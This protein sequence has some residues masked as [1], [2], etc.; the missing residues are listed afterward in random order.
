MFCLRVRLLIPFTL[1]VAGIRCAEPKAACFSGCRMISGQGTDVPVPCV[2]W[3]CPCEHAASRSVWGLPVLLAPVQDEQ[4]GVRDPLAMESRIYKPERALGFQ[5]VVVPPLQVAHGLLQGAAAGG[6]L[7]LLLGHQQ[8]GCH[9]W[10]TA[11]VFFFGA[12]GEGCSSR[13]A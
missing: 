12:L 4:L 1:V 5:I 10:V 11:A 3:H 13:C 7:E 2:S 9:C 6:G 8:P